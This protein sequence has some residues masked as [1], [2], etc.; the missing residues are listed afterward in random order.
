MRQ[1]LVDSAGFVHGQ[2]R[3]HVLQ[4]GVRI[5]AVELSGLDQAHYVLAPM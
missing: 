4:V 5:V 1:E 2:A 3:E